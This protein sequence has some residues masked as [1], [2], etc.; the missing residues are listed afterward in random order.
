MATDSEEIHDNANKRHKR[1]TSAYEEDDEGPMEAE[2]LFNDPEPED[3]DG[4][5][6]IV[7]GY[8][9]KF[10]WKPSE[11]CND[12]CYGLL[13]RLISEQPNLGTLIKTEK[14]DLEDGFVM[15]VMSI[16]NLRMYE[17]LASFRESIMAVT[18]QHGSTKDLEIIGKV[19]TEEKNQVG[20]V[21]NERLGNIPTQLIGSLHQC[22]YDDINWSLD[23]AEDDEER[24]YYQFTHLVCLTRVF[25]NNVKN[26]DSSD[27]A[28]LKPEERFYC[29]E[30]IVKFMWHT[31]ESGKVDFFE[32]DSTS[33]KSKVLPEAMM[34]YLIR[35]ENLKKIVQKVV[36]TF[37]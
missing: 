30:A 21:V 33:P 31:G 4:I 27:I 8:L 34:L 5:V 32:N 25:T 9:K 11:G 17:H 18:E 6:A 2:F 3:Y 28:Y 19:L 7:Q 14:D 23:N 15:A 22:V 12:T 1:D 36:S 37:A 24:R 29:E 26:P 10:P 20:L 35:Y 13:S 16:L